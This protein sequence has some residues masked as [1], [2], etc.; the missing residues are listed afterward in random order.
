MSGIISSIG[1]LSSSGILSADNAKAREVEQRF[2]SLVDA[3][4]AGM[5]S[6][7]QEKQTDQPSLMDT[8]LPGDFI[9]SLSS[10]DTTN[11]LPRG[12]AANAGQQGS[13]NRSSKLYEQAMELES[14]VVKIMLSSMRNTVQK[15]SLSGDSGFAGKMYE[16]MFYDEMSRSVTRNAGFGLADQIY[17]QLA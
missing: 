3:V 8:R 6:D 9:S 4:K 15:T 12:A 10:N 2:S 14:Y 13:I 1:S 5:D 16:D 7:S 11:P 17:L